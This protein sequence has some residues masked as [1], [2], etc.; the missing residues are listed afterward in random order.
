MMIFNIKAYDW[1]CPQ[2][3][4]PK[5]SVAEI[6]ELLAPQK[7]YIATLELE[8]KTLKEKFGKQ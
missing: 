3:I 5:Y 6:Q 1:N 7:Q 8:I 2:H 4:N